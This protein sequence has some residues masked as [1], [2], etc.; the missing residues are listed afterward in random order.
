MYEPEDI[1][2]IDQPAWSVEP[3]GTPMSSISYSTD[4]TKVV[5]S[6]ENNQ[7]II[8]N[9]LDG[10]YVQK[11]AQTYTT[12]PTIMCAFHPI[13]DNLVLQTCKDGFIF[14]HNRNTS[15]IQ[16]MNRHLGSNIVGADVDPFGESFAIACADGS[17]RIHDFESLQRTKA[18]VKM[19]GRASGSQNAAIHD[20]LY[21]SEDSNLVLSAVGNDRVHIWDV[22]SGN[23]ERCIIGPHIRGKGLA[24]YDNTVVTASFRDIKMLEMWDF[25]SSK[26]IKELSSGINLNAVSIA[27]NGLV[28]AICSHALNNLQVLEYTSQQ[29]IGQPSPIKNQIITLSISPYGT[30]IICGSEQGDAACYMVRVKQ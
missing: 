6:N 9:S 24:M 23:S 22:R 15:E 13:Q 21:H 3:T 10:Q 18:L 11:L 26:K 19:T 14:L 16:S 7:L 5:Y 29:S 12:N 17:I 8:I 28:M 4:G 25:G 27:K 1:F 20:I 2:V 30:S